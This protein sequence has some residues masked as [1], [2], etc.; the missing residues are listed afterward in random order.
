MILFINTIIFSLKEK[1]RQ[2]LFNFSKEKRDLKY[3]MFSLQLLIFYLINENYQSECSIKKIIDDKAN[4]INIGED[5]KN[6]LIII[7]ILN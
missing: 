5:V 7:Q 4:C 3:F 2:I 1:E 6:F